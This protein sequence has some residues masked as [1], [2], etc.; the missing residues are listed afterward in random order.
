MTL[1][2]I[3]NGR[4]DL[5]LG[6]GGTGFDAAVLGDPPPTAT[7][8]AARFEDF[9][10]AMDLLLREPRTSYDG[11]FF[12]A[13]ESR[14]V[15]G[16]T[17]SPRVPFTVAAAGRR[18]LAVAAR[19]GAAWVT[20]GPRSESE[21][22]DEWYAAVARQSVG[23]DDACRTVGRDPA[24]IRRAAL[25]GLTQHWAQSSLDAWDDVCGRLGA[26]GFTDVV[27]HWPRPHDPALPGPAPAVFD[28]ICR[29]LA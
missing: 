9:V 24:S 18:A 27:V 3:S 26:L 17:Q 10:D 7:E 1:D 15:P 12:T 5:G 22:P 13:V 11:A 2:E 25:I 14:T 6:A 16:C 8:R 21:E 23:L 29:R 19:Q 20:T 28:E 4:I